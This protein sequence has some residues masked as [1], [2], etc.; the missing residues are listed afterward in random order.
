[1]DNGL[2]EQ[3]LKI[4]SS[5]YGVLTAESILKRFGYILSAD[6]LSAVLKSPKSVYFQWL[7][8]PF[9]N[10]INGIILQQAYDYQVY[11]QKLFID[12]LVSGSGN[13]DPETPGASVR[14]NLEQTRVQLTQLS[15]QFEE[16][17][18]MH[19]KLI[20]E[21]QAQLLSLSKAIK[22]MQ[23]NE[24][25]AQSIAQ[26]MSTFYERA[27]DLAEVLRKARSNFK[28]IILEVLRLIPLLPNYRENP[29]QDIENRATLQFDD[30]LG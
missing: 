3:D 15:E 8:V 9:K 30:A 18:L 10:I 25:T 22:P 27:T 5:T 28:T 17:T 14:D 16:D 1:M 12:Y 4:L 13:D 19:K 24:D 21:S 6:A 2:T 23:D 11:A 29:A 20:H 26:S 7:L